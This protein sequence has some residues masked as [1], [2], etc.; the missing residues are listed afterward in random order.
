MMEYLKTF[1]KEI[2]QVSVDE[3]Y[4]DFTK[5]AARYSSPIDGALEIKEGIKKKFG[6]TVNVGISTNKL[7][8]KMASD[9]E[10]PDRIHTLFPEEIEN[11]AASD[12]RSVYGRKIQCA[13]IEKTG[14]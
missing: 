5:I 9:F 1:T 3:C 10:K 12:Q 14:D 6:F 7:L 8:A 13:G 11:V 4:M 2:E